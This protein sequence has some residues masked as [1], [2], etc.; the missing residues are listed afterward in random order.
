MNPDHDIDMNPETATNVPM[1]ARNTRLLQTTSKPAR[2][3]PIWV[4]VLAVTLPPTVIYFA[5]A[6][7]SH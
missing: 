6:L 5:F 1:Y 4:L 7:F 2:L 3:Y